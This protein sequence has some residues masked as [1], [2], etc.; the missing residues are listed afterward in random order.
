MNDQDRQHSSEVHTN[1]NN[2]NANDIPNDNPNN[3][4]NDNPNHQGA[5][6][7]KSDDGSS[8]STRTKRNRYISLA[9]CPPPQVASLPC[10]ILTR[11]AMNARDE[12]S[13]AT[14][15]IRVSAVVD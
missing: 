11:V 8:A 1:A 14:A 4:P 7:R 15:R 5:N 9:W 2:D 13:N 6:K 3:D 12:R 10:S